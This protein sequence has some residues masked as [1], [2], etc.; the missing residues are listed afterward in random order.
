[1]SKP[2]QS[3]C[4]EISNELDATNIGKPIAE[5]EG[6]R[7]SDDPRR[8]REDL[9]TPRVP[10]RTRSYDSSYQASDSTDTFTGGAVR[11]EFLKQYGL[12]FLS[13]LELE[14]L[15][16]EVKRK[17]ELVKKFEQQLFEAK[18]EHE[19][20]LLKEQAKSEQK[21]LKLEIQVLETKAELAK[22]Q[23]R[24]KRALKESEWGDA[25]YAIHLL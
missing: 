14:N 12:A 8:G 19:L 7:T 1:M 10:Y 3:S 21:I 17:E 20:Q 23:E 6:P 15:K 18:K 9:G 25:S 24:M 11:P 22:V 16:Q 5:T 2:F 4:E 13:E